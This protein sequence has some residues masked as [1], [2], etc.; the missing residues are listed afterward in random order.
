MLHQFIVLNFSSCWSLNSWC[1]NYN[2][3][4]CA[5]QQEQLK[6]IHDRF[7]QD[8]YQHLQECKISL[9]GLELHQIDFKGTVKKQSMTAYV[10]TSKFINKY[11]IECVWLLSQYSYVFINSYNLWGT[12][13]SMWVWTSWCLYRVCDKFQDDQQLQNLLT[14]VFNLA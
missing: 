2:F 12:Y 3:F 11:G 4:L 1:S 6:L 5:E 8:I 9:E 10:V 13:T 14:N 7:K